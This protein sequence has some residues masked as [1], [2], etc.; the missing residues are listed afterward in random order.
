[1]RSSF[2]FSFKKYEIKNL[3]ESLG[4]NVFFSPVSLHM[5]LAMTYLG[6][7]GNTA[8]QLREALAFPPLDD[9]SLHAEFRK[10]LDTVR[11]TGSGTSL[12]IANRHFV[13]TGFT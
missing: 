11:T 5:A 9:D 1:M 3:S 4:E 10:I 6:A 2:V 7:K 12:N 8:T 13:Q